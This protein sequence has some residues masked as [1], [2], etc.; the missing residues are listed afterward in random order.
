MSTGISRDEWLH[1]LGESAAPPDPD[2]MTVSELRV[3]FKL[4]EASLR[5]KMEELVRTGK[6]IKT[7]KMIAVGSG[8]ARRAVAYKLVKPDAARPTT[9]RR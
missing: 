2:A 4:G 3:L 9:R 7:V 1:A 5:R 8:G 6:A